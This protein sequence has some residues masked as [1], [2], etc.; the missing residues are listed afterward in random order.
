MAARRVTTV[1]V[2]G[3]LAFAYAGAAWADDAA[4]VKKIV[5][6]ELKA[7]NDKKKEQ[8]T[9]DGV[10]KVKWKDGVYFET[11]DKQFTFRIGGRIHLDSNFIKADSGLEGPAPGIGDDFDDATFFRRLRIG[12]SGDI[13]THVDY[14]IEMDFATPNNPQVK[15]GYIT[16]KNLKDCWGCWAPSIRAGQ[17]Y[18]PIGLETFT[19]DNNITMIERA[20]INNLHPERSIGIDFF[21]SFWNERATAHLGL[22]TPDGDD[23]DNGFGIWDEEDSDGGWAATGRFTV[24]PWAA[25]TCRFLHLGASASYRK[26]NAV[27]YRA[28]PG[29]GRGPRVLDTG[30]ITTLDNAILWNAEIAFVWNSLHASAEYTSVTLDDPTH[31]DPNF[32]GYYAQ[33][34]WFI[35]GE[36][37]AYNWKGGVWGATRP[38]CNFLDN[39][40]CCKG[41]FEV[42]ARY[43]FLDLND[44]TIHGGEMSTICVGFNWYLNQYTRLMFDYVVANI[45][46]RN[47]PGGVVIDDADVNAFLMRWDIHF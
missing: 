3:L 24:I 30:A 4:D 27:Q 32:T 28:R 7:A 43:D 18:E 10:F 9:K 37:R 19:S 13:T 33:I 38:C 39:N 36:A 34:G 17:Q 42:A 23:E 1:F 2:S 22:F 6:A 26:A 40:C 20:S 14:K 46:D 45:Q 29:L 5:Q 47:G 31:S 44:G 41:A 12:I 21:D 35:T 11:P 15:D 16:I 25:D 8:D